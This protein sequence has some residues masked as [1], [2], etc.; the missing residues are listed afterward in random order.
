MA[1]GASALLTADKTSDL[2][3]IRECRRLHA[4]ARDLP[5][6]DLPIKASEV[7]TFVRGDVVWAAIVKA[8]RALY[9]PGTQDAPGCIVW[10]FD[11]YF[12]ERF[13]DLAA[14]GRHVS[15]LRG[16]RPADPTLARFTALV[17]DDYSTPSSDFI[18]S[19]L[20]QGRHVRYQV[21]SFF[22]RRLAC[23]Y[24]VERRVPVIVDWQ[25]PTSI[26]LFPLQYWG[27]ALVERWEKLA[28]RT[29]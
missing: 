16:T 22:R 25:R 21:L 6:A 19:V 17:E 7:A 2:G 13:S 24:I 12:D 3:M 4:A 18:P 5:A 11:P 28:Q 10:S 8:N 9:Q 20:S 29:P 14:I 15:E 1:D 26:M 27:G 23:G